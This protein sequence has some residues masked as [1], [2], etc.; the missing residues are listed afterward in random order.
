MLLI[1]RNLKPK[2]LKNNPGS[3]VVKHSTPGPKPGSTMSEHLT[4]N[5]KVKGSNPPAGKE[6]ERHKSSC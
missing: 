5:P 1:D 4:H 2:C 6:N 3:T